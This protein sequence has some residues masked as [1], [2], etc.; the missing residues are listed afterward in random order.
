MDSLLSWLQL[1][2]ASFRLATPLLFAAL[3]GLLFCRALQWLLR[4]SLLRW[5]NVKVR[6]ANVLAAEVNNG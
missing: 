2:D 4:P 3:A 1:F 6:Q 5:L